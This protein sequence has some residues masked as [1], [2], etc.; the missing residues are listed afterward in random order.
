MMYFHVTDGEIDEGPRALPAAWKNVSGL[1]KLNASALKALGWLPQ[2][3]VGFTPFDPETQDRTGPV[4][5]VQSD[6]VVSTYTVADK[7]LADVKA[8]RKA[9]LAALRYEKEIGGVSVF[10]TVVATDRPSQAMLTGAKA[11]LDAGFITGPIDWKAESGFVQIDATTLGAIAEA[12]AVHIQACFT[13]EAALAAQID[14]CE[15]VSEVRAVD[16]SAGWA[17]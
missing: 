6:K 15:S 4:N 9:E 7:S 8:A 13:N 10:G 2:E 14:A 3:V 1:D 11:S 5:E 12:V 16:L 17:S